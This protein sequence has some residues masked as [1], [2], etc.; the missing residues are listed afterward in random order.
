MHN[1]MVKMDDEDRA[2]LEWLASQ[3]KQTMSA[4]IRDLVRKAA[5]QQ[6]KRK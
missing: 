3:R 4:L 2:L 5:E 6:R 1:V